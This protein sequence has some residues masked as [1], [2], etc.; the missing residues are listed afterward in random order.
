MKHWIIAEKETFLK[1]TTDQAILLSDFQKRI[2]APGTKYPVEN[3][4][5][6]ENH[7]WKVTIKDGV[8]IIFDN[9][10][11][12]TN[13]HWTLSWENDTNELEYVAPNNVV[14]AVPTNTFVGS[15][16]TPDMDFST[17]I[18][19]HITYGEFA[20][21]QEER[22]FDY[23]H[24][25]ETAYTLAVFLEQVRKQFGSH[26]LRITS[27]YRPPKVN[28]RVGGAYRSEHLFWDVNVGAVDF[29]I[30]KVSIYDVQEYCL[31]NWFGSVGKGADMGFVHLGM[32]G[33]KN[34]SIIW[35]Y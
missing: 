35:D 32:R 30:P 4:K 2:V 9:G 33:S 15:K 24:Q 18:T 16:L 13:S 27:G 6:L 29:N 19:E 23:D 14:S 8:W 3:Y 21:Y 7:H 10:I 31:D 34:R 26:P 22:R 12:G 28:R 1:T 11:D 20:L 17:R 5:Q 25:C